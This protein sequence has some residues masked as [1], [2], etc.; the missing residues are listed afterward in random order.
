MDYAERQTDIEVAK[1]ESH[2]KSVYNKTANEL[3]EKANKYFNDFAERYEKEHNAFL[4]G[5]YTAQEFKLWYYTQVGRGE[6]WQ[7]LKTDAALKMTEINQQAAAYINSKTPGV[8]ALNANFTAYEIEKGSGIAFNLVNEDTVRELALSKNHSE[9]RVLSVNPKRDYEWNQKRIQNELLS[10]IL[11]GK[12]IDKLADGFL[13]VMGSNRGAAI[14][15]AR[16]AVTSAQNGGRQHTYDK[17]EEL[18]IEIE[19]E[20]ITTQDGRT[21][22]SHRMLDGVIVKNSEAFPNKLMYPGD[23]DG[24]PEEVYNCRCSMRAI[25][26]KYKGASRT[27]NTAAEYK[28]W[29]EAKKALTEDNNPV[30]VFTFEPA[31]SIIEVKNRLSEALGLPVDK[32]SLGRMKLELANEYLDGVETFVH[33]F[34][35]IKGVYTSFDT[36]VGGGGGSI[37]F[38]VNALEGT[39]T[40]FEGNQIIYKCTNRLALKNPKNYDEL[41]KQYAYGV[42]SKQTYANVGP[43]ATAIHELVHGMDRAIN[44]KEQHYFV[45]GV[46]QTE[47]SRSDWGKWSGSIAYQLVNDVKKEVFGGIHGKEVFEGTSYLGSY[48]MTNNQEMLAEAIS[49]EYVSESNP[50]SA[51]MLEKFKERVKEAFK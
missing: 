47:I 46:L 1:I 50:Y 43:K 2:L 18:G 14:R 39:F 13:N 48:S 22:D 27:D 6:H 51:K 29:V 45:N 42:K 19:K 20:W 11:Q 49:Y 23:P 17:A 37:V 3:Q 32:I 28:K 21:R 38:G 24:E 12:S 36:K 33:D 26:P 10:G 16:T 34:P 5:K 15:N 31:S 30:K 4:Q 41:L 9:F 25:M 44:L 35:Q 8:Y 40:R 7:T